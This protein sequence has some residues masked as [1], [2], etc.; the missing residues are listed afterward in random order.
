M[1]NLQVRLAVLSTLLASTGAFAFSPQT[2]AEIS[3]RAAR[4]S[5]LNEVLTGNFGEGAGLG[6]QLGQHNAQGWVGF[7]GESEDEPSNRCLHHFHNPLR[8]WGIEAGI[9]GYTSSIL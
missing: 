6:L 7:G 2:H 3:V 4:L 5:K 9:L 1:T 8:A